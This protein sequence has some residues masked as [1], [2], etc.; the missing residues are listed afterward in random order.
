MDVGGK[1]ERCVFK[2][3]LMCERCANTKVKG[4]HAK[5]KKKRKKKKKNTG[6]QTG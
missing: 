1:K 3:V 5:I 4:Q 6:L 2:N